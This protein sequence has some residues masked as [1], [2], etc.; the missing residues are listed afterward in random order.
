MEVQE[1]EEEVVP[2]AVAAAAVAAVAARRGVILANRV[3]TPHVVLPAVL[4]ALLV[5][6]AT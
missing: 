3:P 2:T 1:I 4:P 5:A 6:P